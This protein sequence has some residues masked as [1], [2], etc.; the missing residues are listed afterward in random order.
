MYIRKRAMKRLPLFI[1]LLIWSIVTSGCALPQYA[2]R[3]TYG[4]EGAM[5][6]S[7]WRYAGSPENPVHKLW[8]GLRRAPPFE[9][10]MP[11]GVWVR[12]Q[13]TQSP[14][15]ALHGLEIS[16]TGESDYAVWHPSFTLGA[17]VGRH[18]Y[19]SFRHSA[20]ELELG[21]CGWAF[22]EVLRTADGKRV[23]G[24]PILLKDLEEL[25][26]PP[27]KVERVSIVTGFSCF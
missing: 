25:F 7:A 6:A 23:F 15:L 9:I 4:K 11:D 22:K 20:T 21:A 19:M 1:W 8:V 27:S 26:G 18:E 2:E 13:E 17:L 24:F 3:Y 10:R 16:K 12:S 14:M 5:V